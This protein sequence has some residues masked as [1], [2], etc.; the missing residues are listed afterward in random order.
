[1]DEVSVDGAIAAAT[2]FL[3]LY[4][5]V[6]N[7]GDLAEWTA[8]SHPECQFC[9]SVVENVTAMHKQGHHSEG[10]EVSV[11]ESRGTEVTPDEYVDVA[12]RLRQGPSR[13]LDAQGKVV[14]ETT[15]AVEHDAHV[16]VV[17]EASGPWVVRAVQIDEVG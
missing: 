2:Y 16:V 17:R 1:M 10:A 4:P 14:D 6:Y 5:Y 3:E 11:L 9:A 13:E 15:S 7:T 8:M 12:L